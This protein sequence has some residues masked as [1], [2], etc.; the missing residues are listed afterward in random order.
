MKTIKQ[1]REEYDNTVL[2]HV[3]DELVLEG[4]ENSAVR[5]MPKTIP[6][7]SDMPTMLM[8]RRV[9]YR[10]YPNKQV[11]ALY[12]SKFVNK[13][14]SIP[15]GPDGNLNLSE[16]IVH[17]EMELDEGVVRDVLTHATAG[18]IVGATAGLP[19]AVAGT[20]VGAGVG[21]YKAY[22][23]AKEKKVMKED[24]SDSKYKNPEGGLTKSGVMAYRREHPGSKLQTAVTTKPSKL[25]KGSK[26]ANRRKSFCARM[27]GMKK[28]LTSAKTARDPDSRINKALRK[29][30]CEES[31]KQKLT[32]KRQLRE[33]QQIDEFAS[34]LARMALSAGAGEAIYTGAKEAIK[35]APAIASKAKDI[36]TRFMSKFR[37]AKGPKEPSRDPS[38]MTKSSKAPKPGSKVDFT[39]TAGLPNS[40][41]APAAP[42]SDPAVVRRK[43]DLISSKSGMKAKSSKEF[44]PHA[45]LS[46]TQQS[47]YT[48]N[49][50][51][52][53]NKIT[54][55]QNMLNEGI[56][57]M[58]L[59]INGR[60]VTLNNSMAKKIVRVYESVNTKNKKIV[61]SMLNEDLDSFKKLLNFSIKA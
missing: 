12:Y 9:A 22:K 7:T 55:I 3:S 43:P 23:K 61:E 50:L 8:F 38:A 33:Q 45:S 57:T 42:D 28:R 49:I 19:G 20:V 32:E 39:P 46:P 25:K 37:K 36:A 18:H 26:A 60:T 21:A 31:F 27:G 41:G 52:K 58:D 59:S 5:V 54:D 47:R 15:F 24:W 10:M 13:Y 17:D 30:N 2:T 40:P 34:G 14:L 6:S 16:A 56:E 29:W 48:A 35:R 1:I 44:A 11:V 4:R 51:A 53:E